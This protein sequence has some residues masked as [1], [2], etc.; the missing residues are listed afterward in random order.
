MQEFLETRLPSATPMA[1]DDSVRFKLSVYGIVAREMDD[2]LLFMGPSQHDNKWTFLWDELPLGRFVAAE[3]PMV[4]EFLLASPRV[5]VLFETKGAPAY[6][7]DSA[8]VA[9]AD[10]TGVDAYVGDGFE[11][12]RLIVYTHEEAYGPYLLTTAPIDS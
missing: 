10:W 11:P 3:E 1:T 5:V 2:P 7:V 4:H 12:K 8:E 9:R 6:V